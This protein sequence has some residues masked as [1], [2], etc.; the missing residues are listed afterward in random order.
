MLL[1]A[2]ANY[3]K[4]LVIP[5]WPDHRAGFPRNSPAQNSGFGEAVA[6]GE[7][8]NKQLGNLI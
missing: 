8:G 2:G 7:K 3:L 6:T 5:N 1:V 4:N